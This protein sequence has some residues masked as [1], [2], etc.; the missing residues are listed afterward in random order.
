MAERPIPL[1]TMNHYTATLA[2]GATQ[3]PEKRHGFL[4][5]LQHAAIRHGERYK[6]HSLAL[7]NSSFPVQL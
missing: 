4:K 6:S 3:F 2:E 1:A 7:Y 5:R